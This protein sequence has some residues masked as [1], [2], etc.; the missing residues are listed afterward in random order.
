M[1][2]TLFLKPNPVFERS[3]LRIYSE[4][5]KVSDRFDY[6]GITYNV[7]LSNIISPF[8]S[9][10]IKNAIQQ[11]T[12]YILNFECDSCFIKVY[13]KTKQYDTEL[14]H[15]IVKRCNFMSNYYNLH[16]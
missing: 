10:E 16:V 1:I 9:K 12:K 7:S 8:M 2:R 11:T 14:I 13:S 5:T 6:T 3:I 4:Y 15:E